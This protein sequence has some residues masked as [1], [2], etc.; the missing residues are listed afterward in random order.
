MEDYLSNKSVNVSV[1][2]AFN[3]EGMC[4]TCMTRVVCVVRME[5][6]GHGIQLELWDLRKWRM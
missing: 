2:W 6:Q 5:S 4:N 1:R 3:T